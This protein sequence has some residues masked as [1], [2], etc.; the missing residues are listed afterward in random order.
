ILQHHDT[1]LRHQ[2]GRWRRHLRDR[3]LLTRRGAIE[4]LTTNS[5]FLRQA[6]PPVLPSTC[7]QSTP[8]TPISSST[9][10]IRRASRECLHE[11]HGRRPSAV[12]CRFLEIVGEKS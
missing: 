4:S 6:S 12:P 2:R 11:G 3:R 7:Q 10:A 1:A 9:T 8:S 5:R